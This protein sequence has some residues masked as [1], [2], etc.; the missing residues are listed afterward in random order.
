MELGSNNGCGDAKTEVSN[1]LFLVG[2]VSEAI[3]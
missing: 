1:Q 3:S 2:R